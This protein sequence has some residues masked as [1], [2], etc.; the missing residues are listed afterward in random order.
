MDRSDEAGAEERRRSLRR[1]S[2]H[3]TI[4]GCRWSGYSPITG[5][6]PRGL[7]GPARPQ[8]GAA[9]SGQPLEQTVRETIKSVIGGEAAA[10]V[11]EKVQDAVGS[12]LQKTAAGAMKDVTLHFAGTTVTHTVAT[13][14]PVKAFNTGRGGF[15]VHREIR[16]SGTEFSVGPETIECSYASTLDG[17]SVPPGLRGRIVKKHAVPEIA[18]HRPAADAIAL[19]DMKKEILESFGERTEKLVADLNAN[20]PWKQTLA[21]LAPQ[22]SD[23]VGGFSG[24]KDWIEARSSHLHGPSPDLPDEAAQLRAPIELWVLGAPDGAMSGKLL[25]LWGVSNMAM[26]RFRNVTPAPAATVAA[27]IEPGVV[28][29]WWVIRV[30]V[31]L[32][33]HFLEGLQQ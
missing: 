15:D 16:F 13:K 21:L 18:K 23:W 25:A 32:A 28:G 14:R 29:D 31:D 11:Q 12:T 19:A 5:A 10:A 27:G 6:E 8:A 20:V 4:G 30:G 17:L 2:G 26:N 1:P 9:A 22:E 3:S 7:E 33:E 24:T